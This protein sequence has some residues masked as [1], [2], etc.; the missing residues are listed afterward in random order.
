MPAEAECPAPARPAEAS[1]PEMTE[2]AA[3]R[4][5]AYRCYRRAASEFP[6]PAWAAA[7][8]EETCRCAVV[9]HPEMAALA[10]RSEETCECHPAM[11]A[12]F[13]ERA[14]AAARDAR[15]ADARR[16]AACR[17]EVWARDDSAEAA[18]IR[19]TRAGLR[20]R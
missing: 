12:A 10:A 14:P 8:C 19:D 5:E 15:R 3:L 18:D 7:R 11:G 16:G 4:E 2:A 6:E 9:Q 13:P 20:A 17:A 1:R